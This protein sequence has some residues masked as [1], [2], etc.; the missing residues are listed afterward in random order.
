MHNIDFIRKNPTEFDNF[1]KIRGE[2]SYSSTILNIDKVKRNTQTI[3]QNLLADKNK[4]S[5]EI[6][7]LKSKNKDASE[8]LNK[9]EKI[10]NE[11]SALKE[12]E[13]VKGDELL[14]I[15]NKLPNI[16]SSSTPIGTNEQIMFF[17]EI[18]VVSQNLN[19]YQKNILK[20]GKI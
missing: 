15:L 19:F 14:A 9:V 12:L 11:T 6:G 18:Q 5:K 3:L 1:M 7:I 10:N 4:L 13:K 16:I 2:N 20:L 17:I 8:L